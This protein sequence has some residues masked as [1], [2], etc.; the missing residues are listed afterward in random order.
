MDVTIK[1]ALK[2]YYWI[3]RYHLKTSYVSR[4]TNADGLNIS[5]SEHPQS[6]C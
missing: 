3:F 2:I 1:W 6:Y 4:K 5:Q